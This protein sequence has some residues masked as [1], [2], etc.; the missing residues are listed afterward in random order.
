[1]AARSGARRSRT[2]LAGATIRR[3]L[4]ALSSLYD[5]LCE[6][7][8]VEGNP[9]AGTKRP[10]IDSHEGKTPALGDGQARTLLD[11]PDPATGGRPRRTAHRPALPAPA[12]PRARRRG[13]QPNGVYR[14]V[15]QA[16]A[17]AGVNAESAWACTGC[18]PRRPTGGARAVTADRP[19]AGRCSPSQQSDRYENGSW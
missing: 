2:A 11:A 14:I 4:S 10:R 12:Y 13:A 17:A 6:R 8:A 7:H 1:M 9:V 18:A 5:Y 16:A 15:G 3:K 19:G